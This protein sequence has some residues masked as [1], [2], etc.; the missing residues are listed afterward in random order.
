MPENKN[1]YFVPLFLAAVMLV[2]LVFG[3]EASMLLSGELE[4]RR[5]ARHA[6]EDFV[7]VMEEA[8]QGEQARHEAMVQSCALGLEE[9]MAKKE[10][11]RQELSLLT[12]VNPWT[13]MA[14]G[15]VPQLQAIN[16]SQAVDARCAD[17]L[18][19]MMAD[20]ELS[21][22]RPY[23][24]SS[25]RTQEMQENLYE[26]KIARLI[27]EGYPPA[28]APTVAAQSVAVPGTSEHQLGLAVDIIDESYPYLNYL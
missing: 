2:L 25:Y 11:T 28:E 26:N 17:A 8:L 1:P 9:A 19:Q 10:V 5:Q 14:E 7:A 22:A 23:I 4:S 18:R 12:L 21:G 20:C 6:A 13:P 15:Y 24:C 3:V 27:G 16:E